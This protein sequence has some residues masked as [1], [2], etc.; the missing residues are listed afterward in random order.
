MAQHDYE[1]TY[2]KGGK[3]RKQRV[4]RQEGQLDCPGCGGQFKFSCS[5]GSKAVVMRT[6]QKPYKARC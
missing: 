4:T 3:T 1:I 6:Q 2:N 5:C